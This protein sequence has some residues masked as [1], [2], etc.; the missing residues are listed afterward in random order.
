MATGD[1]TE[2]YANRATNMSSG[3]MSYQRGLFVEGLGVD[4]A[5]QVPG[6]PQVGNPHPNYSGYLL[7]SRTSQNYGRGTLFI[8]TY[9]PQE[10]AQG[11]VPP[12]NDYADG[13]L[14]KSVSFD[15]E[16][17]VI[18]RW[19]RMGIESTDASGNPVSIIAYG[20]AR[21]IPPIRKQVP[22]YEIPVAFEL[23]IN[24][25]LGDVF[26]F[27]DVIVGQTNKIHTIFGRDLRFVC[28]GVNQRGLKEYRANYRWYAD[29][30]VPNDLST[31]FDENVTGNIGRIG[32]TLYPFFDEDYIIPPFKGLY[33]TGSVNPTDPPDVVFFDRFERE[34]NGW[35]SLPGVV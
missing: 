18:P 35:Q 30:G 4:A 11:S 32:S 17:V 9:V 7:N 13:F 34:P 15:Y 22:Y 16:D 3:I 10:Y 24:N 27:S 2:L 25:T 20:E 31:Q 29:Q 6:I 1:V 26:S 21:D 12:V 14:G 8:C 5:G 28:Q 23:T 33:V 19:K